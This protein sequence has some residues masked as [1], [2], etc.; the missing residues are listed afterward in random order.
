MIGLDTNIILRYIVRDDLAQVKIVDSYIEKCCDNDVTLF[1]SNIVLC[2]LVWVLD[3]S[4]KCEKNQIIRT[5]EKILQTSQFI[6]ED[7]Q[8][9]WQALSAY[10]KSRADFADA[11]IGF[12]NKSSGC[13]E[14]I[15]FDKIA[16]K[17][18]EFK[19]LQ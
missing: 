15:T 19:L 16:A 12:T 6:F 7:R 14:T 18:P 8:S 13:K 17:L 9:A 5:I 3:I 4:Y 2:E 10:K 11:L 1:I